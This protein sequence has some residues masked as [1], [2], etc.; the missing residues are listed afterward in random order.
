MEVLCGLAKWSNGWHNWIP[1]RAIRGKW[2]ILAGLLGRRLGFPEAQREYHGNS[3]QSSRIYRT[4]G[5][6]VRP[7]SSPPFHT[8]GSPSPSRSGVTSTEGSCLDGP[9]GSPPS[10]RGRCSW[11]SQTEDSIGKGFVSRGRE[12]TTHGE[13]G[14][15]RAAPHPVSP[16]SEDADLGGGGLHPPLSNHLTGGRLISLSPHVPVCHH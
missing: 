5:Q 1:C 2:K 13:A 3:G 7:I 14:G 8:E 11:R 15:G 4:S 9:I 16:S 12:G 10:A 6:G